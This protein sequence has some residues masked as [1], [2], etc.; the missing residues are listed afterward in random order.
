MSDFQ[1]YLER[2]SEQHEEAEAKF[3]EEVQDKLAKEREED[4]TKEAE[5]LASLPFEEELIKHGGG[6]LLKGGL[7]KLGL[8]VSKDFEGDILKNPVQAI[9][10]ESLRQAKEKSR[11]ERLARRLTDGKKQPVRNLDP[12][13]PARLKAPSLKQADVELA[14]TDFN[15]FLKKAKKQ[16]RKDRRAKKQSTPDDGEEGSGSTAKAEAPEPSLDVDGIEEAED[17]LFDEVPYKKAPRSLIGRANKFLNERFGS[18]PSR[19]AGVD[20]LREVELARD[21]SSPLSLQKPQSLSLREQ[22]L[23]PTPETEVKKATKL[24]VDSAD[25]D[26]KAVQKAKN[27]STQGEANSSNLEDTGKSLLKS[28]GALDEDGNLILPTLEEGF[29]DAAL[30]E[31]GLNPVADILALGAGL[32][33][34]F[35][36]IFGGKKPAGPALAHQAISNPT[37]GFGISEGN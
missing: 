35:G 8:N 7:K 32:A 2:L 21:D 31:G 15:K 13:D 33:G 12:D 29:G 3:N 11:L 1:Q 19:L 24:S 16:R 17:R 30:A 18:Q 23:Q 36:S 28:G 14:D 4:E 5:Q 27:L 34:L 10:K 9:V 20:R 37:A 22:R 25:S 26:V 6:G